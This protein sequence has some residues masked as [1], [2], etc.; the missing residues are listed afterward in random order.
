M[1]PPSDAC[2]LEAFI[3][4]LSDNGW[5]PVPLAYGAKQPVPGIRWKNRAL[6]GLAFAKIAS[7]VGRV[8]VG[9]R[10]DNLVV[11]DIDTDDRVEADRIAQLAQLIIG[12][13]PAIRVGRE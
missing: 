7:R 12:S 8:G 1:L 10:L 4:R 2:Q 13:T 11:I 5:R 3:D 6:N 9:L